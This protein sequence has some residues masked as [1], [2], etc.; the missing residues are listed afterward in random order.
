M[1]TADGR[2]GLEAAWHEEDMQ[3]AALDNAYALWTRFVERLRN[4]VVSPSWHSPQFPCLPFP[5]PPSP[6][7]S[8]SPLLDLFQILCVLAAIAAAAL[9]AFMRRRPQRPQC[10]DSNPA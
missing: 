7:P 10:I 2:R 3:Q 5:P 4:D 6:P 1:K 9:P 8:L